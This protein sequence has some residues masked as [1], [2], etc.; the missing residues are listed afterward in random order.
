M[1]RAA[2]IKEEH[3]RIFTEKLPIGR[4]KLSIAKRRAL[5]KAVDA[6]NDGFLTEEEVDIALGSYV[7]VSIFCDMTFDTT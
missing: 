3:I 4:D 5:F 7:G 6:D 1:L 2:D